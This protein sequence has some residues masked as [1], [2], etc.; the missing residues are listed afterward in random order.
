MSEAQE[1]E[2]LINGFNTSRNQDWNP[3][4]RLWDCP[5]LRWIVLCC[6]FLL[7]VAT[8]WYLNTRLYS[9]HYAYDTTISGAQA[10]TKP[11]RRTTVVPAGPGNHSDIFRRA[12]SKEVDEAWESL[13]TN[14]LLLITATDLR[15]MGKEP[16]QY[17]SLAESFE[18]GDR[19][20]FAKFDHIHSIHC[21]NLLRKWVHSE[22]YFPRGKPKT[23]GLVHVNHCIRSLLENLLC[24]VD[25]GMFTYQW[26]EGEPLPI[27]D[28]QVDRQCRDYGALLEFA[29]K[30]RV[31]GDGRVKHLP[32]P[33]DAVVVPQD[34]A[35]VNYTE[36][37]EKA[38]PEKPTRQQ[39][40]QLY[41][42]LY[43][44]GVKLWR[45]TG[46]I[47]HVELED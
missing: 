11:I 24:H 15:R 20:Y 21:L 13:Y 41:K 39:R 26:V 30:N 43:K 1:I 4:K 46:R 36:A 3:K 16:S 9:R 10:L 32:R 33:D 29:K 12:P 2:G 40:A 8:G 42:D 45:E 18:Y 31:D 22:Y 35:I 25:Y 27:A 7:G 19:K 17:A 34:P 14:S 6:T 44:A 28:F 5:T 23:M 38:H 47:P 37:Y